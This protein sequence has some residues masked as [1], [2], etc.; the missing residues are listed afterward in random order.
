M[1]HLI[2]KSICVTAFVLVFS[3][4][5][6]AH[7][8]MAV[9]SEPAVT[10]QKKEVDVTFS[11]SHPFAGIGMELVKPKKAGVF[12]EGNT[13]DVTGD[14]TPTKVM[15]FP[16][17]NLKYKIKRPGVYTFFMEPQPYWEP[18][19]DAFIIHYTKVLVPAYGGDIGWDEEVGLKTEIVPLLRPFG[20]Y[21]GNTFVGLVK[22]DGKAVPNAEVEVE[23]YNKGR[24][25]M[26]TDYHE[27]QVI[28]ADANGIFSFTCPQEGWWGF[29]ALNTADFTLKV[30]EGDDKGKDKDVEIGAVLWVYMDGWKQQ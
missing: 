9:P 1:F 15:D 26:P 18:A 4:P 10:P 22:L 17:W 14:L 30:Q 12:F 24:F 20:N 28:K 8:G 23:L 7:F 5:A 13:Q 25:A 16:A 29:A 27:T 6:F 2:T 3:A 11:F 19:E 21:A